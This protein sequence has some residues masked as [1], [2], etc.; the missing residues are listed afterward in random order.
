MRDR[1]RD[2]QEEEEEAAAELLEA[3]EAYEQEIEENA[4]K[5]I[6]Q[7]LAEDEEKRQAEREQYIC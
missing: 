1:Q 3:Q 4:G 7:L 2:R 6:S 5:D